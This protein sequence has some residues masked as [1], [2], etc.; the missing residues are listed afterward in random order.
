[1]WVLIR[2]EKLNNKDMKRVIVV[3]SVCC[4][5][6][7]TEAVCVL[8]LQKNGVAKFFFQF[9]TPSTQNNTQHTP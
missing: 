4:G 9:L 6:T 8:H 2:V 5:L 1:M 7:A 3:V